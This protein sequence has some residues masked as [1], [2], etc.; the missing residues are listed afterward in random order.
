MGRCNTTNSH[1]RAPWSLHQWLV[2]PSA[3]ATGQVVTRS[4]HNLR[5]TQTGKKEE[6][7]HKAPILSGW[8]GGRSKSGRERAGRVD[9]GWLTAKLQRKSELS[10]SVWEEEPPAPQSLSVPGSAEKEKSP[11]EQS[12]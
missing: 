6:R 10:Q 2:G 3:G 9:W 7:G 5:R 11:E 1:R 4:F 8:G 12:Q